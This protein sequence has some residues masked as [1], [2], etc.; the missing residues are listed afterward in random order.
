MVFYVFKIGMS[1]YAKLSHSKNNIKKD[2]DVAANV[3]DLNLFKDRYGTKQMRQVFS[4]E[5]QLKAGFML[6]QF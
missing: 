3:I 2:L 1:I 4:E 6:G 5:N